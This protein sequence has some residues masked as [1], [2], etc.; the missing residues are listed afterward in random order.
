M[1][2]IAAVSLS[3]AQSSVDFTARFLENDFHVIHIATGGDMDKAANALTEWEPRADALAIENIPLPFS[4][5]QD[6]FPDQREPKLRELTGFFE[7]PFSIGN[8]FLAVCREWTMERIQ[9]DHEG[10]FLDSQILF[11][12]GMTDFAMAGSLLEL[13]DDLRFCDP[14]FVAGI[15]KI[16]NS[17][18]DLKIFAQYA[19]PVTERI[20]SRQI[21]AGTFFLKALNRHTVLSA[22]KKADVL[23]VPHYCWHEHIGDCGIDALNEKI[24]VSAAISGERV[25]FLK[26][27]GVRMV[28]DTIPKMLETVVG[29]AVLESMVKIAAGFKRPSPDHAEIKNAIAGLAPEPR[30]IFPFG[31]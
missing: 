20:F 5:V 27:R 17:I 16:L 11:T 3:N 15:P 28:I 31:V 8:D 19:Y 9:R 23:V 12:S 24:V 18:E 22:I 1:K 13:S 7:K 10:L 26:Q 2:T 6:R 30:I 4:T 14:V 21:A 25:N 29:P